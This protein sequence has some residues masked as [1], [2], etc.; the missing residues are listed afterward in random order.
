MAAPQVPPSVPN[1]YIAGVFREVAELLELEGANSFKVRAYRI[2][3]N[4]IEDTS[5]SVAAIATRDPRRLRSLRGVGPDL[6]SRI[7]EIVRTGTLVLLHELT[8]RVPKGVRDIVRVPGL[9]LAKARQLVQQ[10]GIGSIEDLE[11]AL[12]AGRVRALPGF[13]ERTEAKLLA[14]IESLEP[15]ATRMLRPTAVRYGESVL[16]HVRQLP[17]VRHAEVAGSYRRRR[18]TVGD[19][20]VVAC[21]EPGAP[22]VEHFL[23]YP[24]IKEVVERSAS[25]GSVVLHS[26][27]RVDLQVAEEASYG[28]LLHARTGSRAHT[29]R[30]RRLAQEQGLRLDEEGLFHGD[31]RIAGATEDELFTVLGLRFIPPELR[32][33]RGE[34]DAAR[35]GRLPDLVTLADI[36]GD[37]QCHSTDSD[38]RATIEEMARAA[39]SL[40][41]EYLAITDHSRSLAIAGGLSSEEFRR[42]WKRIDALNPELDTLRVLKGAEVEILGDGSLDLDDETLA[43]LDIVLVGLHSHLALPGPEQ[44]RR[45]VRALQHPAV[46]VFAHPFGRRI[47]QREPAAFDLNE[48]LAVAADRGIILEVNGQP[49]RL[50]LDDESCQ[51]ALARGVR[52]AIGTDAHRTRELGFMRWGV[53]QARRGWASA[54]NVVNTRSLAELLPLLHRNR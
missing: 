23:A 34:F 16:T 2:A 37:L 24:E 15:V 49:Q 39:Q 25:R 26:G 5:E 10:L 42:Q 31:E 22:L 18:E 19:L 14:T 28:A 43:E 32:E 46:D 9:G 20:D 47:G 30:L 11:S 41:Y 50:D 12:R 36:R 8:E 33:D 38:G 53:D 27:V 29:L 3:A 44:T 6:A 4:T 45:V 40:G 51:R 35:E 48:V 17:G 54:E 52:I 1:G 21:G 13:G 7:E